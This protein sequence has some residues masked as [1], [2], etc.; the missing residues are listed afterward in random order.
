MDIFTK[1]T[2][3]FTYDRYRAILTYGKQLHYLLT[4]AIF[5]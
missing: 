3:F 1:Y 4:D 2:D 5:F